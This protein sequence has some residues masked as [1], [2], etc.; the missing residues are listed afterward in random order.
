MQGITL[1]EFISEIENSFRNVSDSG[2]LD[3]SSI[4][5]TVLEELRFLGADALEVREAFIDI[6][7]N[8]G[9]LPDNFR[10]LKKAYEL[11][12]EGYR[13]VSGNRENIT[14]NYVFYQR[15]E[16]PAYFNELT[17]EYITSCKSK[18]VTEKITIGNSKVNF[19]YRHRPLRIA[20][21]VKTD[22]ID[23]NCSNRAIKDKS[24]HEIHINNST[25]RVGFERG[26]VYVQ[27]NAIPTDESGEIL[28]PIY[29][30]GAIR[31]YITN[32]VKINIVEDLILNGLVSEGI[33][34]LYNNW[35]QKEL[36]LK[37]KAMTEAKMKGLGKDWGKT[38][39]K[40]Q[41]KQVRKFNL[42]R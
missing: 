35:Q 39:S 31:E 13:V 32:K 18:L 16:N 1:T 7:N 28:I 20:Q 38:F 12:P 22:F 30:T 5:F 6:E 33:T 10:S 2:N 21:G 25:V 17:G 37:G 42:P 23:T 14:D 27:Y 36:L 8:I 3:K 24:Y 29:S 15:I 40:Q 26:K 9:R 41:T 4:L 34:S 11:N 19:C